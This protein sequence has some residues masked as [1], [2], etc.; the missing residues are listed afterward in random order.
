[1]V[2]KY[3]ALK[4]I[5]TLI[6]AVVLVLGLSTTAWANNYADEPWNFHLTF[7]DSSTAS[8]AKA[9][10]SASYVY[11]SDGELST[12][13]AA[14]YAKDGDN[15]TTES[16][17]VSLVPLGRT[18]LISNTGYYARSDHQVCLHLCSTGS[19]AEGDAEGQWSPDNYEGIL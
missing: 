17:Y 3:A 19:K 14:I 1:M 11:Y 15:V 7:E 5:C 8:R 4:M 6:A 16:G 2:K 13:R 9:D 18:A 12:I 10:S